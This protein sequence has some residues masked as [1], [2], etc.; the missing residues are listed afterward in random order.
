M[1]YFVMGHK[2]KLPNK[3]QLNMKDI[4]IANAGRT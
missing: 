2:A 4:I 3:D 1:E